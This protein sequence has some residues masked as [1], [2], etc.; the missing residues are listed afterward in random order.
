MVSHIATKINELWWELKDISVNKV[1]SN[2][3]CLL[4]IMFSSDW[5][6][7]VY[8]LSGV[9]HLSFEGKVQRETLSFK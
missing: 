4:L 6:T 3:F 1:T 9:P 8:T 5:M 7:G 2:V